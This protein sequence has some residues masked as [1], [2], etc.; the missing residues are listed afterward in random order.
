MISTLHFIV[1]GDHRD[2]IRVAT[3]LV[4]DEHDLIQKA[5][6]WMLREVGKRVSREQLTGFLDEHAA[7]MP[8]TMLSYATE[9]LAP[10][11]R[12]RYRAMR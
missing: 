7:A 8:R 4:N 12:A 2:A 3:L 5:V 11:E 10:E 9:H 1:G 6:G